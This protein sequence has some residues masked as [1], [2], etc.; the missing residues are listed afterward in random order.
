[1][2]APSRRPRGHAARAIEE[3]LEGVAAPAVKDAIVVRALSR[4]GALAIPEDADGLVAFVRGPLRLAIVDQLDEDVADEVLATLGPIVER[5]ATARGLRPP[6]MSQPPFPA[7]MREAPRAAQPATVRPDPTPPG[8]AHGGWAD[9]DDEDPSGIVVVRHGKTVRAGEFL[10][11]VL[12]VS[13][14]VEWTRALSVELVG[15]AIVRAVAEIFEMVEAVEDHRADLPVVLFDCAS[16]PFHL[17]SVATF[18]SELPPGSW[19][20]LLGP[21]PSD[22]RTARDFAGT[23]LMIARIRAGESV[24]AIGTR[25]LSLAP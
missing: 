4:T 16:A 14:N 19:L 2:A 24:A 6:S 3:A 1:M 13:T 10:P 23:T 20:A 8:E 11:V 21:Q 25:C 15:R 7:P 18:A 5:I 17:E 9:L 12:V 22:E